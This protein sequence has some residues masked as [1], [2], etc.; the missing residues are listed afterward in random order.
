MPFKKQYVGSGKTNSKV[1]FELYHL[2]ICWDDIPDN[3]IFQDRKN[4][5][6]L[7]TLQMAPRKNPKVLEDGEEVIWNL[8]VSYKV[9]EEQETSDGDKENQKDDIPF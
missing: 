4:H 7:A 6:T 9:D 5:K 8:F 3:A 1:N 2:T